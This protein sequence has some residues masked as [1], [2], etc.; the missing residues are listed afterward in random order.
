M[1]YIFVSRTEKVIGC[2]NP[3]ST[4]PLSQPDYCKIKKFHAIFYSFL[5]LLFCTKYQNTNLTFLKNIWKKRNIH[6]SLTHHENLSVNA[7]IKIIMHEHFWFSSNYHWNDIIYMDDIELLSWPACITFNHNVNQ[8]GE[9]IRE[10]NNA[11]LSI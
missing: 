2:C 11:T 7:V 9:H 3:C 10:I 1:V 4:L 6:S 5:F 8:I